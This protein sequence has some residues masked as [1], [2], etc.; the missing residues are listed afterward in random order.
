MF[1]GN[2]PGNFDLVLLNDDIEAAYVELK[3]F[4]MDKLSNESKTAGDTMIQN[5]FN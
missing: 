4:V 1:S 5:F 3:G 2:N